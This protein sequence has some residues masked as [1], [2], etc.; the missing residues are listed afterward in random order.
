MADLYWVGN[1]SEDFATPANYRTAYNGSSSP[2]SIATTDD[3][4]FTDMG[5]RKCVCSA[6]ATIRGL[7]WE[8]KF[9]E[10]AQGGSSTEKRNV[11]VE[12]RFG[13][14]FQ[15]DNSLTATTVRLDG[16]MTTSNTSGILAFGGAPTLDN[17]RKFMELGRHASFHND[18]TIKF[19]PSSMT[20]PF[21]LDNGSYPKVFM[22]SGKLRPNYIEPYF[23]GNDKIQMFSLTINGGSVEPTSFSRRDS[24][25]YF[26]IVGESTGSNT[27]FSTT[28]NSIDFGRATL[29]IAGGRTTAL[30]I[31]INGNS[32][33]GTTPPFSIKY[34]A[35]RAYAPTKASTPYM[36]NIPAGMK[37]C[38]NHLIVDEGALIQGGANTEIECVSLPEIK[39]SLGDFMQVNDGLYRKSPNAIVSDPLLGY[40]YGGTGLTSLGTANQ[41][42]AVN[43][44]ANAIEWQTVSGGG[45]GSGT[46][47]SVG[48]TVPTG[49]AISG[50]PITG[51]GTLAFTYASGYSLPTT[52]KQGQW[53]TAY[54]WG[55][56]AS[57]GYLTS[58]ITSVAPIT[59]DTGNNRVGI[60]EASPD[61]DLHVHSGNTNYSVK[62]EHGE[63]Q[64]LFNRYGHIQIQND[65]SSPTDGATLDNPVWH[66]G[67]RDGGQLDIAFGNIS[68]QLVAA[69]DKLLEL[70][71]AS[72]SATGAKQIG[73]LGATAVGQQ[74]VASPAKTSSAPSP[75]AP[76]PPAVDPNF[77]PSLDA[78]LTGIQNH[79]GTLEADIGALKTA[80]DAI[81]T[82]LSNFGLFT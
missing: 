67:Q 20:Q 14:A 5:E 35:F 19:A 76:L 62:F 63:G 64:T 8:A 53:D 40:R 29:G 74:T 32:F 12:K 49:F 25:V 24:E 56:H 61:Y 9:D 44:G 11:G 37:M 78:E 58:A 13:F 43:A 81:R 66:L 47:T 10:D 23:G 57:A 52:A 69:S 17:G 33:Y 50:S 16:E 54:G 39:G 68:T 31:P 26:L 73:F 6:T 79:I 1:V 65:N 75:R 38:V 59:L 46:V 15:L 4:Y 55:N 21:Y 71:R 51:A 70:K 41:V 30:S 36:F 27:P 7:Y 72:N 22:T 42:L 18:I 34:R 48:A 2:S 82:A 77:D 60:N 45:G 3:I 80:V 28:L